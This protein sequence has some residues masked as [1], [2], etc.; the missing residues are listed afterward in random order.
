MVRKFVITSLLLMAAVGFA[1]AQSPDNTLYAKDFKGPDVGSKVAAAMA[2]CNPNAAI[3]CLLVIDPSL[4]AWAPGTLPTLCGHCYLKDYRLGF[5]TG[6]GGGG[7]GTT[8]NV[9]GSP[10]TSPNFNSTAPTV[11]AGYVPVIEKV[12]GSNVIMETPSIFQAPTAKYTI[13]SS[14]ILYDDFNSL[15]AA[16]TVTT[17]ACTAGVCDVHTSAAHG[18]TAGHSFADMRAVTGWFA[19]APSYL[20]GGTASPATGYGTFS[21]VTTPS[22]TEFTFTYSLH[23]GSGSGGSV[24]KADFWGVYQT[25]NMPYLWGHGNV[26]G[27]PIAMADLAAHFSSVVDC[28]ASPSYLILEGGQNDLNALTAE[29]TIEGYF[30]SIYDQ[31]HAA[32]CIVIQGSVMAAYYGVNAGR[33]SIWTDTATLNHNLPTYAPNYAGTSHW[34]RYIDFASYGYDLAS[35]NLTLPSNAG[36]RFFAQRVNEAILNQGDSVTGPPP[37]FGPWALTASDRSIA[38]YPDPYRWLFLDGTYGVIGAFDTGSFVGVGRPSFTLYNNGA[39][40]AGGVAYLSTLGRFIPNL[41]AANWFC[42]PFGTTVSTHNAFAECFYNAGAGSAN[43]FMSFG[44]IPDA[45]N[46]TAF[47]LKMYADGRLQL[48][49]ITGAAQCLHV[50]VSGFL[51]GTGADCAASTPIGYEATLNTGVVASPAFPNRIAARSGSIT[52]CKFLTQV[53]DGSTDLTFN[54][55]KGGTSILSGSAATIAHATASQTV[56]TLTLTGT[57]TV[58][59]TDVWEFDITSGTATWTGSLTCY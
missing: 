1:G 42:E 48:P 47:H 27:V 19:S 16:V 12:S 32:G 8:V 17:W 46:P 49:G 25:A 58:T 56:S 13:A 18:L 57:I 51:T 15:S 10:V 11:D 45:Y 9:N 36:G 7:G 5:L 22:S 52:T 23:T 2:A 50:D 33:Q 35:M 43:N 41:T 24:R 21:V 14:S 53:A 4:A 3:P 39:N 59:A 38:F 55:K 54:V 44:P 28:T 37:I 29:W 30:R 40:S 6:G 26:V 34:D 20:L 31:A